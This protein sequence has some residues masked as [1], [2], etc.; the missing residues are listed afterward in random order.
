[1][2]KR[3]VSITFIGLLLIFS[4]IF[5]SL[6]I[7]DNYNNPLYKAMIESISI[8]EIFFVMKFIDLLVH[9]ICGVGI[10]NGRNKARSFFAKWLVFYFVYSL[11]FIPVIMIFYT[12][13]L[14]FFLLFFL[15]SPNANYYFFKVKPLFNEEDFDK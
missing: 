7:V 4:S 6:F 13:F 2:S 14:S 5:I 1:M 11:F 15:Y 10:L 8:P 9:I 12:I 3:P